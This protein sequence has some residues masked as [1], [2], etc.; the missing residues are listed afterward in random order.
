MAA[1]MRGMPR[2]SFLAMGENAGAHAA[3]LRRWPAM[4]AWVH[5]RALSQD[6]VENLFSFVHRLGGGCEGGGMRGHERA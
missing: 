5:Q 1:D 2:D 4:A 3:L 6:D